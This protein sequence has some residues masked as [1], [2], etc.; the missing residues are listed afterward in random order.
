MNREHREWL[1]LG[2]PLTSGNIGYEIDNMR[3]VLNCET[4]RPILNYR[5]AA[6]VWGERAPPDIDRVPLRQEVYDNAVE[7]YCERD[8]HNDAELTSWRF[9]VESALINRGLLTIEKGAWC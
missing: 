1:Q 6:D 5:T 8:G 3:T 7:R 4:I 2:P 9:A